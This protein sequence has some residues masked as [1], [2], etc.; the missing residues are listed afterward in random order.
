M[1]SAE[2]SVSE[3]PNLK[4]F[5]GR[6]PTDPPTKLVPSAL[7]II[8]PPPAPVTKKLATALPVN[9][10]RHSERSFDGESSFGTSWFSGNL[11]K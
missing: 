3:P 2:D 6:I 11:K 7:A 5:W 1:T 4:I 8:P 9:P 10:S